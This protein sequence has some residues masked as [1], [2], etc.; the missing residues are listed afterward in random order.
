LHH[1]ERVKPIILP[2]TEAKQ[3]KEQITVFS[4]QNL[5]FSFELHSGKKE[6]DNDIK[7]PRMILPDQLSIQ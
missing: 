1:K 5:N 4:H 7:D 6:K 3:Q 2:N